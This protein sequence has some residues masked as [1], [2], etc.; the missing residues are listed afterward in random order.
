[1]FMTTPILTFLATSTS[2]CFKSSKNGDLQ[3]EYNILSFI[4]HLYPG[5]EYINTETKRKQQFSIYVESY[6]YISF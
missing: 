5:M 1:M 4:E 2:N 6:Y 3:L